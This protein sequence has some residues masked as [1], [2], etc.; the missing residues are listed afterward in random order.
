[1]AST[2]LMNFVITAGDLVKVSFNPLRL[3]PV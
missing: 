1:M 3:F 2:I